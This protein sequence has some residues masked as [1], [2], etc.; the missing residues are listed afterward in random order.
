VLEIFPKRVAI[1][2]KT[3]A[4]AMIQSESYQPLLNPKPRPAHDIAIANVIYPAFSPRALYI[5]SVSLDNLD[6]SSV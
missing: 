4:S 6:E 1:K 2:T 3:G 5:A